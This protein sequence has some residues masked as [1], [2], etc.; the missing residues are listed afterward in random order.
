MT[1][2]ILD[3]DGVLV[4]SNDM[5]TQAWLA[6]LSRFGL[7]PDSLSADQ[8]MERMHGKRNDQIVREIFGAQLTE[9][10]VF[11]HGAAKEAL[12]REMMRPHLSAH[13]VRGV[14]AFLERHKSQPL[15]VGSNA[16]PA[17]LDFVLDEAKLRP[18]FRAVVNGHQV[19]HPKPHP[20]IYLRV[21]EMLGSK[22]GQCVIF[23]DSATGIEA[24]RAA[25]ARVVA[26]RTT[27]APLPDTDFSIR[28]FQ[29]PHLEEWLNALQS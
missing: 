3:M 14:Q 20:E 23:E 5:H 15:G 1:A 25:G 27:Q 12:Y 6:Y 7:T 26:V 28:D 11:D 9:Q 17:N 4:D 24:A 2:L 29:D 19:K 10:A 22:P 16:E 8:M 18:Y 21:A 13:L